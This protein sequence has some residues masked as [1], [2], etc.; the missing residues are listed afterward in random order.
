MWSGTRV[1]VYRNVLISISQYER[2]RRLRPLR[3]RA[4]FVH[5]D[6][7]WIATDS[8]VFDLELLDLHWAGRSRSFPDIVHAGHKWRA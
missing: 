3:V 6:Q 8:F 1:F 7:R 5:D 4:A 2:G